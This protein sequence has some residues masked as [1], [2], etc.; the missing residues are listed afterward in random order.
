MPTQVDQADQRTLVQLELA[1]AV[2][3]AGD[4]EHG[5][6]LDQAVRQVE[7]GR[8]GKQGS[9]A[10]GLSRR[11][12]PSTAREPCALRAPHPHPTSGHAERAQ[13]FE[14]E[15]DHWPC[16]KVRAHAWRDRGVRGTCDCGRQHER[17]FGVTAAMDSGSDQHLG[18]TER[19]RFM[20]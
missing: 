14:R 4:D 20:G 5:Y 8:I 2:T 18:M 15:G 19:D 7:C 16:S 9:C 12:S 13:L 11:T 1:A 3:L 6:P 17:A 10:G